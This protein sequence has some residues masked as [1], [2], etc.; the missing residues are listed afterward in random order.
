MCC[1]QTLARA[2]ALSGICS[3]VGLISHLRGYL[4]YRGAC[5]SF[6]I[7]PMDMKQMG[8]SVCIEVICCLST[9]PPAHLWL[10]R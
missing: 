1:W 6:S 8:F 2:G 3:L 10:A 4:Y 5:F 7:P 9:P